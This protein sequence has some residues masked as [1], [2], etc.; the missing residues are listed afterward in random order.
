MEEY[1]GIVVDLEKN[2][3]IQEQLMEHLKQRIYLVGTPRQ[4]GSVH[5]SVSTMRAK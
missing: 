1:L 4:L 5:I 3:Y 2:I